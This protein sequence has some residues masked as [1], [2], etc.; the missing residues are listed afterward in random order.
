MHH[1][2]NHTAHEHA[3]TPT[4][5]VAPPAAVAL[6]APTPLW[7]CNHA[8]KWLARTFKLIQK[9]PTSRRKTDSSKACN[10]DDDA[11]AEAISRWHSTLHDVA[12]AAAPVRVCV[13]A[14]VRMHKHTQTH[15]NSHKL[16]H[17]T[18]HGKR[19]ATALANCQWLDCTMESQ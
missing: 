15:T 7:G 5:S 13:R 2:S 4:T 1:M 8:G 17:N 9:R 3:N 18:Y 11:G 19:L 6:V 10:F 14:H 16:T 12:V